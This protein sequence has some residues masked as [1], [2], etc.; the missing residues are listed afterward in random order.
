MSA[1]TK[2]S[3]KCLIVGPAECRTPAPLTVLGQAVLPKLI[4]EDNEAQVSVFHMTVPPMSGPPLH[5]HSRE[6]EWLYVLDAEIAVDV[7]GERTVLRADGSVFAP[8]GSAHGYQNF[9]G[10]PPRCWP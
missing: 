1:Q 10:K 8:R 9:T 3:Y 6:D 4:R 2:A 7:D 5:R